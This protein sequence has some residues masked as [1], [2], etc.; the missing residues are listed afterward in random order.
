MSLLERIEG[1][2]ITNLI[3]NKEPE[4]YADHISKLL[5]ALSSNNSISSIRLEGD[6]L[7]D[8]NSISR[9]EVLQA[10]TSISTLQSVH[11]ADSFLFT[12]DIAE[13]LRGLPDLLELTMDQLVLQGIKIDFDLLESNL[14]AHASLKFFKLSECTTSIAEISLDNLNKSAQKLSTISSPVAN[15]Q[16]A[17]TA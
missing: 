8:L 11:L 12:K 16:T 9:G 5:K 6:F 14:H 4:E 15:K 2:D 13:M 1:N 10:L 3:L 7:D 17:Q